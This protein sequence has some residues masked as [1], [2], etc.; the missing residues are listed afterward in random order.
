LTAARSLRPRASLRRDIGDVNRR[1]SPCSLREAARFPA[2][3]RCVGDP[4]SI[5]F[6]RDEDVD[7]GLTGVADG[8]GFT[9]DPVFVTT[10][11]H[12]ANRRGWDWGP[13]SAVP[14]DRPEIFSN[15]FE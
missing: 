12:P 11:R 2:I 4:A 6:G 7:G 13:I 9:D 10:P 14:G 3:G 15:G 8:T 5:R 1:T